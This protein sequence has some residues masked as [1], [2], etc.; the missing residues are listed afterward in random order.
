MRLALDKLAS[1]RWIPALNAF[2]FKA[3]VLAE[4]LL[5]R[6]HCFLVLLANLSRILRFVGMK[7]SELPSA[8]LCL[9]LS[10]F[11]GSW[12]FGSRIRL[13]AGRGGSLEV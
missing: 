9:A 5:V 1:S 4:L 13:F 11:L 6:F 10:C 2:G 12:I 8:N 7:S 3:A